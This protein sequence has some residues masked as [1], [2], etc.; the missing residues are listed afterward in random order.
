MKIE[1]DLVAKKIIRKREIEKEKRETK[2]IRRYLLFY[3]SVIF[4]L[5][6]YSYFFDLIFRSLVE[7]T[8]DEI[9][10]EWVQY[11]A[12][13][14]IAGYFIFPFSMIYN[15]LI[16]NIISKKIIIRII[17]G[18]ATSLLFGALLNGYYEFGYYIGEYRPLKNILAL[19]FTGV[20][21]ELIRI[22]VIR[23][24]QR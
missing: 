5:S 10:Y 16:N 1:K 14:I 21:V 12:Y 24:R 8:N 23:Y 19:L 17:A 7:K 9:Y 18:M 2:V 3:L 20:T 4:I 11:I 13:Y 15:Y 6:I 22:V